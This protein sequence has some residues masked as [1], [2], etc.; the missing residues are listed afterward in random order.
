MKKQSH[1]HV[2]GVKSADFTLIELLVVI[3]IIAILAAI[4]LPALNAARER[5]RSASCVSNL[6]QVGTAEFM[7]CDGNDG[8]IACP[9]NCSTRKR[10]PRMSGFDSN[11]LGKNATDHGVPNMLLFGGFL[12]SSPD[13]EKA[14]T[15]DDA[16]SFFYCPSDAN[17][18]DRVSGNYTTTSYMMLT[19]SPKEAEEETS[20]GNPAHKIVD[21]SGKGIGRQRIGRD[22]PNAFIMHDTHARCS[23]ITGVSGVNP[24][25]HPNNINALALGGHVTS[26]VC[27]TA[28]QGLDWQWVGW[29]ASYEGLE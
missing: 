22:N 13:R 2:G 25:I 6:K 18:A 28:D 12:G 5:G 23:F 11:C 1:F 16:R 27:K 9:V 24:V 29:A 14:L 4:L 15:R 17:I 7:Y 20:C 10:D 8:Y 21:A 26:V 3:A 19:H